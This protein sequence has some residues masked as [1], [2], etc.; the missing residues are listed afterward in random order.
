MLRQRIQALW[1]IG[2][3]NR[4]GNSLRALF[5]RKIVSCN[6]SKYLDNVIN[7]R[8]YRIALAHLR[9]LP[10]ETGG[11]RKPESFPFNEQTYPVCNCLEDEY[12]FVLV[13]NIFKE[14]RIKYI[15]S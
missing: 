3:N 4:L 14:L 1:M 9:R 10:V 5:F 13:C 7:I 8:K 2:F 12:H 6:F 11:W 15:K